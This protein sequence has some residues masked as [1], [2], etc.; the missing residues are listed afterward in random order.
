MG[1][2]DGVLAVEWPDRL[3]HAPP[4]ARAVA[5]DIIDDQ[6]RRIRVGERQS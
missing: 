6:T 5:I 1:V 3:T 2:A 4:G